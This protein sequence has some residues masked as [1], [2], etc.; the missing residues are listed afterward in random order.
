MEAVDLLIVRVFNLH[1]MQRKPDT[2]YTQEMN[3][4][5]GCFQKPLST[6]FF[7]SPLLVRLFGKVTN[8]PPL[9]DIRT[10]QLTQ[11]EQG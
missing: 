9:G 1:E 10:T 3:G 4:S 5:D 11:T 8:A 6:N 2:S 7:L